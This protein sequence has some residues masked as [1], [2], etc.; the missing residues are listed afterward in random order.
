M[1]Y[2]VP[3]VE[4]TDQCNISG[5]LV[6]W[7]EDD[8]A[9]DEIVDVEGEGDGDESS[10]IEEGREEDAEQLRASP[11]ADTTILF[12]RPVVSG[13]SGNFGWCIMV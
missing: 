8:D 11:D 2:V 5:S 1:K 6:A 9:D 13:T 7:A 10:V 4:N 3:Y 12:T